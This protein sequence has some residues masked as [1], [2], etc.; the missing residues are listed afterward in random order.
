MSKT[1]FYSTGY[2]ANSGFYRDE[3]WI[4][5]PEDVR[6]RLEDQTML[7]TSFWKRVKFLFNKKSL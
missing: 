2:N 7:E 3:E 4:D 6:K 1:A 5:F